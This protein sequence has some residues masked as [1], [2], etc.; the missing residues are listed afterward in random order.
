MA[1]CSRALR[2]SDHRSVAVPT[3]ARSAV[4]SPQ[5]TG[6]GRF[7]PFR[8]SSPVSRVLVR[9]GCLIH[10]SQ[11]A[12]GTH[13]PAPRP[14]SCS[15]QRESRE[16]WWPP[17]H[18]ARPAWTGRTSR[19]V[20][21]EDAPTLTPLMGARLEHLCYVR[22]VQRAAAAFRAIS[23]RLSG[24]SF[25]ARIV[26]PLDPPSFPRA[27]PSGSLTWGS[28]NVPGSVPYESS[29]TMSTMDLA[30]RFGSRGMCFL[31]AVTCPIRR[32]ARLQSRRTG[33][34]SPRGCR[35]AQR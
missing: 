14:G 22:L 31:I 27:T 23:A 7:G 20:Q 34:R 35:T 2:G 18:S 30:R 3:A 26:P 12:P 29:A 5:R 8:R 19:C 21:M 33:P 32:T 11:S 10:A 24:L 4:F 17:C 1:S 25:S 28:L 16:F 6:F 15:L 13:R 9:P